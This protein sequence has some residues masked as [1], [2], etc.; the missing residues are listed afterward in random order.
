MSAELLLFFS[1]IIV[2]FVPQL[3]AFSSHAITVVHEAG[4][5]LVA[6]AT[7]R[8][9]AAIRLHGDSSGLTVT[10]GKPSGLGMVL[11]AMAGYLAP[12]IAGLILSA[13]LN[14]NRELW[15]LYLA[16]AVVG[17]MVIW[18]RNW[19]GLFLL[20]IVGITLWLLTTRG[21]AEI[22]TLAV[23]FVACFLLIG[24]T[25]ATWSLV[26]TRA[27]R[28]R[29]DADVLASITWLPAWLWAIIF[30]LTCTAAMVW[31]LDYLDISS[32][33]EWSNV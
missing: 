33:V 8:K 19:F 12:S 17:F 5:A 24:G 28:K 32:L 29:S 4:H 13:L 27:G 18:I 9:L 14:A 16:L 25:H 10:K 11:T 20:V 22:H 2:V 3:W 1:A 26:R 7:G 21:E 30:F 23:W 6:V 31:G 15:A